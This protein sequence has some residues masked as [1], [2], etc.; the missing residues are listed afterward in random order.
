MLKAVI[1]DWDGTLVDSVSTIYTCK[2]VL[3]KKY[4]LP[5]PSEA[6]AKEVQGMKFSV[7][8]ARC[9]PSADNNLLSVLAKDFHELMQ[10][11]EYQSNLFPDVK[12]VMTHLK[13][14]GY[15]LAVATSKARVELKRALRYT[16]LENVFDLTCCGEEYVNKP[17]PAMLLYIMEELNVK[18]NECIMVGD[19]VIDAIFAKNANIQIACTS[20]G[21][22]SVEQLM[23]MAPIAI[24]DEWTKLI[25]IIE[26]ANAK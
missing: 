18:P 12:A 10:T 24:F 6:I 25:T 17:D 1:F 20:L 4:N 19:T 5:V 3:A 26:N 11:D 2:K 13:S 23:R 8:L 21:A 15:K 14:N 9:F 16:G 22:H 7:A